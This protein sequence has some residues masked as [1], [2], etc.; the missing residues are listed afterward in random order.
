MR[1]TREEVRPARPPYCPVRSTAPKKTASSRS[2]VPL[3]TALQYGVRVTAKPSIVACRTR[4]SA[5]PS[6]T[7]HSRWPIVTSIRA[8]HF[9]LVT[10]PPSPP[11]RPYAQSTLASSAGRRRSTGL[12]NV[13]GSP[14]K[15]GCGVAGPALELAKRTSRAARSCNPVLP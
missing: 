11:H 9:L 13:A 2:Q 12:D 5:H 7:R 6:Q 10:R 3:A 8:R 14:C 15:L 1:R 4:R